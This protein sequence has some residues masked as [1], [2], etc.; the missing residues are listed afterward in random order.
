M[1]SRITLV[2]LLMLITSMALTAQ[3]TIPIPAQLDSAQT[4]FL[5]N[6]GGPDNTL[7]QFAYKNFYHAVLTSKRFRLVSR[8]A[9]ADLSFEL[10]TTQ[11][12]GSKL[13]ART[14]V[15]VLNIRDA[16]TQSLLWSFTESVISPGS[17]SIQDMD[18]TT[19]KLLE[20]YNALVDA[21]L[22]YES[23]PKRFSDEGKK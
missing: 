2:A 4:V 5:A 6:A 8:P 19:S 1:K 13:T 20:D 9:D 7:S 14:A 18:K 21:P 11:S 15:L 16:K 17:S 10:T 12:V 23:A 22:V 3:T